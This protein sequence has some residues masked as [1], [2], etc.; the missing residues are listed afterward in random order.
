MCCIVVIVRVY[1][2]THTL[3]KQIFLQKKRE[4]CILFAAVTKG[5]KMSRD[6]KPRP[7]KKHSR[8]EIAEVLGVHPQ[9]I[10]NWLK[11]G[12]LTGLTLAD[13]LALKRERKKV[14]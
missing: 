1:G 9:T 6:S 3:V 14:L 8:R 10:A 12:K 13:V 5:S 4:C 2:K 11:T 7:P